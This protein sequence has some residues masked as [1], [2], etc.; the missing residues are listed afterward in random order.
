[1]RLN[2][3]E[4]IIKKEYIDSNLIFQLGF[5]QQIIEADLKTCEDG[6]IISNVLEEDILI[7]NTNKRFKKFNYILKYKEQILDETTNLKWYRF[8]KDISVKEVKISYECNYNLHKEVVNEEGYVTKFGLRTPQ[9]GAVHAILSN[10]TNPKFNNGIIV[11]PTGTGKT[12]VMLTSFLSEEIKKLLVLTP[13][14]ALREQI[15]NKFKTLGILKELKI[16]NEK[17]KY[18]VVG[19]LKKNFT[20]KEQEKLF[21]E[22]CNVVIT[23]MQLGINIDTENINKCFSHLFIDEAHHITA[24]KWGEIAD[25]FENQIVQ[26]T[27]TPF[28]NDGRMMKGNIIYKYSLLQAQ[29]EKYFKNIKFEYIREFDEEKADRSIASKAIEILENDINSG[30]EHVIMA[31]VESIR[32]AKEVINIYK[33]LAPDKMPLMMSNDMSNIEKEENLKLLLNGKCKIIVCVNMLGEGFD[34]PK[35]KIAAIHDPHKS[36]ATT[37]QFVGRFTR[38]S[39]EN[40]GDA[41]VVANIAN[42]FTNKVI[43][44]LYS[45]DS[46]WNK[47]IR[48]TSDVLIDKELRKIEFLNNFEGEIPEIIPLQNIFPA[49][50]TYIFKTKY[51][52]FQID[53]AIEKIKCDNII[54]SQNYDGNVLACIEKQ[55]EKTDWCSNEEIRET[56][57]DLYIIYF[58][59]IKKNVYVGTTTKNPP[60]EIINKCFDDIVIVNGE[61]TFKCLANIKRLKLFM[62]MDD[63]I[64]K[65]I[66]IYT[67]TG[68]AIYMVV[69]ISTLVQFF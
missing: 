18:P 69:F 54:T 53:E 19:V 51:A 31:R 27:A 60:Y 24:N 5:R 63:K 26:F 50:S 68:V 14:R 1:M 6:F 21:F 7:T 59:R 8:K 29:E 56:S 65:I 2:I 28:R 46:D 16:I 4:Y 48:G 22:K 32:R 49:L 17:C 10:I 67:W 30:Y 11:M 66:K 33:E 12:E 39:R 25:K 44:E 36:I 3:P 52:R 15:G 61:T 9:I 55:V 37:I 35:L 62:N 34:F 23:S 58:D 13:S 45:Q 64:D 42:D 41:S 40:I 47:I 57:F 43:E 20:N 38:T